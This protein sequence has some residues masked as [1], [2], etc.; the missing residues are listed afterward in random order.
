MNEWQVSPWASSK[1]AADYAPFFASRGIRGLNPYMHFYL[2]LQIG[3]LDSR[4][5]HLVVTLN[6]RFV[7]LVGTF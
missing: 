1:T 6:S 7:H 5:V 2:V 3:T 4:L